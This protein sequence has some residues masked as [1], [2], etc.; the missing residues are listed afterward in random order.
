MSTRP[1][2]ASFVPKADRYAAHGSVTSPTPSTSIAG[3]FVIADTGAV[4]DP[5]VAERRVMRSPRAM[6][7][8]FA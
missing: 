1:K 6:P 7:C 5:P 4:T 3:C 8:A 2:R